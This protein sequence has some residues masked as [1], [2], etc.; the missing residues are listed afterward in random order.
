MIV[1]IE[2]NNVEDDRLCLNEI[3]VRTGS[4]V[5]D[6]IITSGDEGD[7]IARVRYVISDLIYQ[8]K[9]AVQCKKCDKKDSAPELTIKR[10]PCSS[11][12]V[13]NRD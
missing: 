3:Q 1:N 5:R 8:G 12:P 2:S 9:G 10:T 13:D 11:K 4:G 7:Y 6:R